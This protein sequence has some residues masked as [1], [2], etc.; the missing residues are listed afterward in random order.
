MKKNLTLLVLLLSFAY[1]NAQ[2]G[3]LLNKAKEK[4]EQKAKEK[5]EQESKQ[6]TNNTNSGSTNNNDNNNSGVSPN[7]ANNLGKTLSAS[8]KAYTEFQKKNVVDNGITSETHKLYNGKIAFSKSPI[9]EK[10]ED[11]GQ[12]TTSFMASDLIYARF[13]LPNS[14]W[15]T[16]IYKIDSINSSPERNFYSE[17]AIELVIDGVPTSNNKTLEA[18]RIYEFFINSKMEDYKETKLLSAEDRTK[19]T[20][21]GF[22]INMSRAEINALEDTKDGYSAPSSFDGVNW[23]M[24]ANTLSAGEH[25]IKVLVWPVRDAGKLKNY[26]P[27][28]AAEFKYTKKAGDHVKVGPDLNKFTS[29]AAAKN[30]ALEASMLKVDY[31]S[32]SSDYTNPVKVILLDKEWSVNT[33]PST[34]KPANRYQRASVIFKDKDGKCFIQ[35]CCW[36]QQ[37]HNGSAY[38][39]LYLRTADGRDFQI[40]C[41]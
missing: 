22:A 15:N 6:K 38:G 34:G 28:C 31:T 29:K 5:A 25:T 27:V 4:T 33:Y 8:E 23:P 11:A 13:Y 12:L 3:G 18:M 36:L 21:V 41:N 7:S 10:Q 16:P 35:T 24:I 17:F 30:P 19:V 40:E 32:Y 14:L 9:A 39:P 37:D 2:I 1:S 26:K 20:T